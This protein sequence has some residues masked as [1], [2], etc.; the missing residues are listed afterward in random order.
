MY[1]SYMNYAFLLDNQKVMLSYGTR[2]RART[3]V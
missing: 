2:S 3:A 1:I